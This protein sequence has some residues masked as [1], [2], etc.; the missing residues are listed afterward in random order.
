VIMRKHSSRNG[1]A[2]K[3]DSLTFD[4]LLVIRLVASS[5]IF[6][7]ALFFGNLPH[8]V[9]VLLLVLSS[10]IAGYDIVLDAVSDFSDR[11]FFSASIVVTVITVLSCIIGFPSEATALV[12][13]YQIGLI[14][15]SYAEGKSR[16]SAL[17]LLRY[18]E[19]S[20]SDRVAKIVLRDGAGHTR[21]EDSI[22]DS[23]GFV[24]KIGMI[25]GVL[26]AVITPFFTNNTFVVSIH[27]ALTIILISTPMSVVASMP[28][29]YITA[30]CYSAEYG[31]VFGNAA[32]MESCAAAKTVLFDND[33]IFTQKD[34]ADAD[35]RVMP[36][37]I[38]KKTFLAFAAHT[39]YYSEQPWAKA[40]LQTYVSDFRLQLID[41]FADYPG[42]GAAADIGGNRV[43]IGTREF[44]DSQGIITKKTASDDGQCFHMTIAAR[45]VGCFSIGFPT[46]EGC[47]DITIGLKENG[48]NRC[49][50]L[51]TENDSDSRSIA[52]E[53]NFREVYGEC[54]GER[55][56]RIVKDIS[57]SAKDPTVYVYASANDLHSAADVDMQISEEAG[58]ADAMIL[59][60]CIPNIPFAFGVCKRAREVAAENAIF[61]F[62]VKAILI[63]L[64]I[65]GYCN[66]WF[67][68]FIDMVA[69]VGTVLNTVSVTKPSL[70]SRILN[71][72]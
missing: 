23:A 55:K 30:M 26:Y 5:L 7:G 25:I 36:E 41:N 58:F 17:G 62:A 46:L 35:V 59:P 2:S 13:L 61:V 19:N 52:D 29:A 1:K 18:N 4:A 64:S 66:L 21:F 6:A 53:L 42:Y 16:L 71:R 37:I 11:D 38:D 70:I 67:A 56:F 47:E 12:L 60:D 14:L 51:C 9:N 28:T 39:I 45:Y 22:R 63:F 10:V 33:G 8:F 50:L 69:A 24:L 65:I 32:V 27:R 44:L 54:S 49:V 57:F 72:E 3:K 20:I 31:V 34:P 43:I 40:I 68:I 48:V 15:V